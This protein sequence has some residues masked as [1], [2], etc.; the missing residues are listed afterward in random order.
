MEAARRADAMARANMSDPDKLRTLF[1][2]GFDLDERLA[3]RL[4]QH[5]RSGDE[6]GKVLPLAVDLGA[7]FSPQE[8]AGVLRPAAVDI[9]H[10][11]VPGGRQLKGPIPDAPE[12]MARY[13]TA[14]L[15]PFADKYP[16]PFYRLK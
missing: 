3:E 12:L 1:F 16:L 8:L 14:T 13:L 6:P 10:K 2:L 5:K 15:V 11:V 9:D 4:A 7:N